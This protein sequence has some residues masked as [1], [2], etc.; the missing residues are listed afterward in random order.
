MIKEFKLIIDKFRSQ[1]KL[2]IWEGSCFEYLSKV[3]ENPIIAQLAPGRVYNIIMEKGMCSA[4]NI[5]KLPNYDDL[6]IYN[7]FNEELFGL[8]ESIHDIMKFFKAGARRTE[9]GKRILILVG[10]VSSGKSTIASL[11][12]KGLEK[13]KEEIYA[14]KDCPIH[15]EPLHLIP[16]NQRK[17][18]E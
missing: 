8:E 3:K 15:E 18:W 11:L 6:A 14:I 16:T 2:V 5:V 10:P 17:E 13:D 9:T 1:E 4:E 12:R 7:F